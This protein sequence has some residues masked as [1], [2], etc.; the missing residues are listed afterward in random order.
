[1]DDRDPTV[2]RDAGS[3]EQTVRVKRR[4]RSP[5]LTEYG[6]VEDLVDSGVLGDGPSS[7]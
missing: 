3:A 5:V 6:S 2:K 4:Y 7:V 1:M